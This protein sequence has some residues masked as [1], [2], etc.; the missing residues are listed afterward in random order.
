MLKGNKCLFFI[1]VFIVFLVVSCSEYRE[2]LRSDNPELKYEK[3]IELY[4]EEEYSRAINLL[5]DAIPFYRG[6]EKAQEL[7][8]YYAMAHYKKGDYILASHY[9]DSF[10][11]AFPGSEHAEEFTFLK[12]YCKY[13]ESP[14]YSLD[15]SVTREAIDEFQRFVDSYPNSDKVPEANEYIDKLRFKLEKKRFEQAKL[16]YRIGDYR[17]A[18]RSFDNLINEFPG[19]EFEEE[20]MFYILKSHHDYA[21]RSIPERQ[22]ERFEKAVEAYERLISNYP[23]TEFLEEANEMIENAEDHLEL[24]EVN[25]LEEIEEIVTSKIE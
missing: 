24:E 14:R 21:D 15:Q 9:F 2:V 4:Y 22:P 18:A 6:T 13:K 8:Y 3:A 5:T 7:N 10:V 23:E 19:T 25:E 16:F 20:A 1:S 12:A 11:S 17:A